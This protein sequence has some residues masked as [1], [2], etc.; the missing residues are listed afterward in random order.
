MSC[1]RIHTNQLAWDAIRRLSLALKESPFK[2]W[3]AEVYPTPKRLKEISLDIK[4][5]QYEDREELLHLIR[6]VRIL[7]FELPEVAI[8][9][10]S[11]VN[12][13]E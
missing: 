9:K 2:G 12:G 3:M 11:G 5:S 10:G 1:A 6:C 8:I 7:V 4:R 13:W